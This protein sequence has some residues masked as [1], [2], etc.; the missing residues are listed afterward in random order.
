[1]VFYRSA[2]IKVYLDNTN[3]DNHDDD[4]LELD[5]V[6]HVGILVLFSIHIIRLRISK[7]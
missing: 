3:H 7:P 6:N 1:M 5:S 2:G 4:P